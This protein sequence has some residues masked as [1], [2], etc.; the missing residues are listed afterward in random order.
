[1]DDKYRG[2]YSR[3]I[4]PYRRYQNPKYLPVP[5]DISRMVIR[6]ESAYDSYSGVLMLLVVSGSGTIYI[7]REKRSVRA[8]SCLL[9][10]FY[11]FYKFIPDEGSQL[12][13]YKFCISPITYHYMLTIPGA[14]MSILET[15]NY[16]QCCFDEAAL[17]KAVLLIKKMQFGTYV[18]LKCIYLYEFVGRFCQRCNIENE[19]RPAT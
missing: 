11:K 19:N 17:E 3:S 9:M 7:N 12:V 1:M 15:G 2:S 5:A 8:G 10:H 6:E 13:V 4:I 14:N 16:C 18:E